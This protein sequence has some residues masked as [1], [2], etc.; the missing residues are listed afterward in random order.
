MKRIE[1]AP[2]HDWEN[3]IKEQGFVYYKGYYNETAAYEFTAA[4]VDT[5]EAATTELF[6]R[7]LDVVQHVIDKNLWDDFFIPKQYAELIKWSWRE[8]NPSFYGRFDLGLSHDCSKIKLLEF[9]A[10]TPTSLLEASVIQW[11]WLQDFDKRKDQFNS[12]HEKLVAHMKVCK[13]YLYGNLN[14]G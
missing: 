11:Y 5:I 8:D 14:S 7:C 9:N 1:I 3:K 13:D 10:D 6:D 2:R 4:E 12:I